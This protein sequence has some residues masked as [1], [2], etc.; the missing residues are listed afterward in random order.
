VQN[1]EEKVNIEELLELMIEKD[2]SDI[3]L[4]AGIPPTFRVEGKTEPIS[5]DVLKPEDTKEIAFSLMS[6]K[7]KA[8][9]LEEKE[10]NLALAPTIG[11]FR[12]NI[13]YQMSCIGLVIR[14]LKIPIQSFK[15]LGLPSILGDISMTT[16]G[17]VLVVGATGSGKS[18]TLAAMIDHR[19]SNSPGHI[20]TIE[21][22]VEFV[23]QHKR[24]IITHREVGLDTHSFGDGLKSALRQAPD[25]IMIGEVRDSNTMEAAITFAET[26]HLC[27]ATLHANN[28][29]QSI[30]RIITFFPADRQEQ[31]YLLLSLNL[32]SIISQRLIP[33]VDDKRIA[34]VEILMDTPRIKDLILKKEI[35]LLKEAM[36]KG[37]QE[38]MQ[39]FD[40]AIYDFY[41]QGKI[42]YE[43][44]IAYADSAND[45]RLRIKFETPD[46]EEDTKNKPTFKIRE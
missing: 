11:R 30:E 39:T 20:I 5:G 43:T 9:F 38:G 36:K 4:S 6:E 22:P 28:A 21:D 14:Q 18:T 2:A 27:L 25:V 32:R 19:N 34:A 42:N 16:R 26:G 24:S 31:I 1:L 41:M 7:Q 44:A 13:F 40:Q 29:N 10:M 12:V 33:T 8:L 37:E 15:D 23:H 35:G 45:L 17:L 3:Y 46:L